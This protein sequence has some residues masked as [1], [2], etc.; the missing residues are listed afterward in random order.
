MII[1]DTSVISEPLVA[2]PNP[3]V[4][5]WL[6]S[7]PLPY[8]TAPTLAEL[9]VGVTRLPEGKRKR[10]LTRYIAAI[11]SEFGERILSF[12][13]S[14]S[15]AFAEIT[16]QVQRLGRQPGHTDCQIAAIARTCGAQIATRNTS[17]F[18]SLD[19]PLINPWTT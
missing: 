2:E 17:D 13:A 6:N 3:R 16:V 15:H 5:Q 11:E 12:D 7:V 19:I 9:W 8:L 14:C 18:A 1:L 4:V 10:T